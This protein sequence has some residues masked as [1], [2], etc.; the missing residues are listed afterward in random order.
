MLVEAFEAASEY[1]ESAGLKHELK[2]QDWFWFTFH[3][4]NAFAHGGK[5]KFK[6]NA[7]KHL[8]ARW[9]QLTIDTRLEGQSI[10]GFI[11]WSDGLQ[12]RA[13]ITIFVSE[14]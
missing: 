13:T 7:K 10:E 11:G 2:Q 14:S 1:A 8:P 9:R 5:W 4:R 12:L 6:A 3:L